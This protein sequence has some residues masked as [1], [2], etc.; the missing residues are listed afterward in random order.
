M[1]FLVLISKDITGQILHTENFNVIL[2]SARTIKGSFTPSFRYRNVK[3]EFIE[4]S[5]TADLSFRFSQHAITIANKLEYTIYD[6]ENLLS[7]GF[8]YLEYRN[9]NEKL[10]TIEPFYQMHWNENRGL[11]RKY[12][13]GT[14]LRWRILVKPTTGIFAGIGAL[15]EY[16]KWSYEGV[17]NAELI[18]DQDKPVEVSRFRGASY[19][20]L[21]KKLSDMFDLDIS[22]YYQPIP[23]NPF[24]D[25]RFA[26]SYELTYNFTEHIGLTALYQNIFDNC[27]D[28]PIDKWFHDFTLGL[29][30]SF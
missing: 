21:K 26:S 8:I 7:G 11:E 5:N 13:G 27:P 17:A 12:A 30:L 14:N 19:L 6:K 29:T 18:P 20:S 10:I 9:I 1:I 15:Y 3:K 25:F 4:I 28:V 2:D 24:K 22:I 23:D 16:E